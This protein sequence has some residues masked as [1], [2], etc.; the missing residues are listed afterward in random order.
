MFPSSVPPSFSSPFLSPSFFIIGHAT[1]I[2]TPPGRY[3]YFDPPPL[4]R[5]SFI[6]P[7][8]LHP[9]FIP[10]SLVILSFIPPAFVFLSVSTLS[11]SFLPLS[12]THKLL[13]T[14]ISFGF[15]FPQYLGSIVY[16]SAALIFPN[17][18]LDLL[19]PQHLFS[20]S[21]LF[22]NRC[23]PSSFLPPTYLLPFSLF[24]P[25]LAPFLL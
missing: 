8:F 12:S 23:I 17:F 14:C 1:L 20:I 5:L 24:S 7:Y 11:P 9:C 15:P 22:S 10:P 2:V 21:S 25:S 3:Y 18:L 19:L 4:C 6:N 13:S 16:L